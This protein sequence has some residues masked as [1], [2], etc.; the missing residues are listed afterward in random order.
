MCI[1]EMNMD[2]KKSMKEGDEQ[3]NL[4]EKEEENN[5]DEKNKEKKYNEYVWIKKNE[6]Q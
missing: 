6:G 3:K 1:W 5:M 4:N 2:E